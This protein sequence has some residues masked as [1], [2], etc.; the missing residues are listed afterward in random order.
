MY[1]CDTAIISNR[2]A[3]IRGISEAI[4]ASCCV[5]ITVNDWFEKCTQKVSLIPSGYDLIS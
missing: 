1:F 2:R 4:S 5:D 3:G